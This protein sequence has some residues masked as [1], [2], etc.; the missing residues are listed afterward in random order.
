MLLLLLECGQLDRGIVIGGP[1]LG[2]VILHAAVEALYGTVV[3]LHCGSGSRLLHLQRDA[4]AA[5]TSAAGR[6]IERLH[7]K[8]CGPHD[9]HG[10]YKAHQCESCEAAA[11]IPTLCW[12]LCNAVTV[13]Q[14][15]HGHCFWWQQVNP[16]LGP[17]PMARCDPHCY[18]QGVHLKVQS[19]TTWLRRGRERVGTMP[20]LRP[21]L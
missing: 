14:I 3:I 21:R 20:Q 15:C 4:S 10:M 8:Y 16:P 18:Q 6:G 19:S 9:D 7:G 11:A 17:P 5:G 12:S 2:L 13:F 1:I